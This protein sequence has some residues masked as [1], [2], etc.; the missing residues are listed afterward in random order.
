MACEV[1]LVALV[2]PMSVHV[3]PPVSVGAA[4]MP[5]QLLSFPE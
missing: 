5:G 4:L 2:F 1:P 3:C